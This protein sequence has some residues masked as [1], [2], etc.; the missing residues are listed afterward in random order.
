MEGGKSVLSG[1][2]I[3]RAWLRAWQGVADGGG[4]WWS[5]YKLLAVESSG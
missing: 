3:H 4:A 5:K 2:G 1:P